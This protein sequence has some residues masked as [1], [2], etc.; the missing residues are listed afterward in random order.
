MTNL[1]VEYQGGDISFA[2]IELSMLD[3]L[4][5]QDSTCT[6]RRISGALSPGVTIV[7]GCPFKQ[8]NLR[9]H[10]FVFSSAQISPNCHAEINLNFD[11]R[12]ISAL[13]IVILSRV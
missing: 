4:G 10:G 8:R 11:M 9:S 13:E 3:R 7:M 12:L 2:T 6:H 1:A 5:G